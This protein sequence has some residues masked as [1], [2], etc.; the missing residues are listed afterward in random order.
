MPP[1]TPRVSRAS[2]RPASSQQGSQ[3]H[4]DSRIGE[5]LEEESNSRRCNDQVAFECSAQPYQL[6]LWR[7]RVAQWCY[8]IVDH[9]NAPRD[10]VYLAMNFLDRSVAYAMMEGMI[11]KEEYELSSITCLFLGLRVSTKA[12]LKI[13]DL[14]QICQSRL[15]VKDI[16]AN[17]SRLLNKLALKTPMISPSTFARC[18]LNLLQ[19]SVSPEAVLTLLEMA[20]YL[21]E[22]SVCDH[23]FA[24]VPSSKL[25]F[26][27]VCVCVTSEQSGLQLNPTTLQSFK[28]ELEEN[29][30]L[31][32]ESSEIK[33]LYE[34]L[35]DIY[36]QS[37]DYTDSGNPN[38][39]VDD[40][41][42]PNEPCCRESTES[43]IGL[44][45]WTPS[46]SILSGL[47]KRPEKRARLL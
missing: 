2:K 33:P 4:A 41:E 46:I 5:L 32:L 21:V 14:L 34:R 38:L 7:N 24:F 30:R 27:A 37:S 43:L 12:D 19:S 25:A 28:Q 16:Q 29:T 3:S 8:D 10:T 39:I 44:L 45:P 15:Q 18:Y 9:L 42:L 6:S 40:A 11:T 31:S 26:A 1:H 35:L 47:A 22:L 20:C 36:K 23:F 17:G 13:G